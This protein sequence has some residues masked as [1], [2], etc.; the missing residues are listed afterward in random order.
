[1]NLC[2]HNQERSLTEMPTALQEGVLN[3]TRV[4]IVL[5]T[6]LFENEKVLVRLWCEAT[7][8]S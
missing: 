4:G 1:M 6:D 5:E 3:T 7:E 2:E 8:L